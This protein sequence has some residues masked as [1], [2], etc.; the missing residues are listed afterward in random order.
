MLVTDQWGGQV[1]WRITSACS[2]D[3]DFNIL[4]VAVVDMTRCQINLTFQSQKPPIFKVI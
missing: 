3:I 2:I 1:G 4:L